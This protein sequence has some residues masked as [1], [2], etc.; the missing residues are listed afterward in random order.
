MTFRDKVY[1]ATREIPKGNVATYGQIA[2]LAGNPKASRAV[3]MYMKTNPD[4]PHT[5]CHRVVAWDGSLTGY[6]GGGGLGSK[7]TML[8]AEGVLFLG[9]KVDLSRSRWNYSR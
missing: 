2:H 6:S 8:I 4:A 9:D 3:G 5:P 1:A 7:K